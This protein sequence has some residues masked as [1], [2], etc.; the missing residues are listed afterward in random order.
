MVLNS[1]LDNR[2]LTIYFTACKKQKSIVFHTKPQMH[3]LPAPAGDTNISRYEMCYVRQ[4]FYS[5]K[6]EAPHR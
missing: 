4:L 1:H 6:S 3:T 5:S 2:S